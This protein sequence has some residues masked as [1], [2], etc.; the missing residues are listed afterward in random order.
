MTL[1]CQTFK[2]TLQKAQRIIDT[3]NSRGSTPLEI[4]Q[5]LCTVTRVPVAACVMYLMQPEFFGPTPELQQSLKNLIEFY[6]YDEI[7]PFDP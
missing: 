1:D 2:Q 7:L 4:V 5:A 3:H 6:R